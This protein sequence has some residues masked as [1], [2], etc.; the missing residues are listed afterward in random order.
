[1]SNLM[2]KSPLQRLLQR[3][4]LALL[5]TALLSGCGTII[6]VQPGHY[7]P[8]LPPQPVPPSTT[9]GALY[10]P[11]TAMTLFD[12]VK[13]R[14]IGDTITILL[15]ERMQASKSASTDATKEST[16]DTGSP[17][18]LGDTITRNGEDILNNE[19]ETSQEFAGKG[20]S[21]QSNRLDGS[22]TVTVADVLPNGNL[23]V[24]G[25]KWLTLN[26]GEEFVQIAGIVRPTDIAPDN[27]VPSFKV[28][29][30]RITYGGN[31]VIPDANRAGLVSR[32]F[33]KLWPL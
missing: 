16:V 6:G 3:S 18:I 29:D 10:Q 1:M 9:G 33:M 32:F 21:S 26:Q 23:V 31:G 2:K 5:G 28:A 30:A 24:R 17:V 4:A 11:A 13:A 7:P 12:D 22:I 8:A 25:E 20:S 14:R 19:W 15:S 27:S